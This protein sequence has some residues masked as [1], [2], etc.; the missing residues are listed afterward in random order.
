MSMSDRI[1][2]LVRREDDRCWTLGCDNRA[3]RD[4]TVPLC[5]DCY[6]KLGADLG[7]D[8]EFRTPNPGRRA[9]EFT[10]ED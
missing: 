1:F 9:I 7:Y 8:P 10:P 2:T 5:P 4:V 3:R 6:R